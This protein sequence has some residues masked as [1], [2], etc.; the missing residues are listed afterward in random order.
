[1]TAATLGV[2]ML[3]LFA[4]AWLVWPWLPIAPDAA[5]WQ[6]SRWS[7]LSSS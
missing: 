7:L 2:A 1:M 3:G 6:S 4:V 5:G